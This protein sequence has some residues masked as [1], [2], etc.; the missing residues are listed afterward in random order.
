[1]APLRLLLVQ[2]GTVAEPLRTE[3]GD[4]PQWFARA[5]DGVAELSVL[6]AHEG[7]RL[8]SH[9]LDRAGVIVTGSP[10]SVVDG[11]RQP[12]MDDLG[13]AL[14]DAGSRGTQVLGVCF[15]QQL[16]ARASGGSVVLNPRGREIGTVE[17]Q[18]TEIGLRDPLF[19]WAVSEPSRRID[20]QATHTDAVDALPP[21][22]KVLASNE[23]TPAQAVR[24]S[25]NVAAVQFHP[26]L[27]PDALRALIE[28]RAEKMRA[29]GLDPDAIAKRV[30][31][32]DGVRV[33]HAFADVCRRG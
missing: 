24:F 30:R 27:R 32:A 21:G 13:A 12:W 31:K 4:Y 15:G 7:E 14:L 3:H 16:L 20:V 17:V 33:L 28:S 26:E 22:V 25:D 10:L 9:A 5:L 29:E 6:R 1:M 8:R 11:Q 2:T 19:S 18:L 23:N